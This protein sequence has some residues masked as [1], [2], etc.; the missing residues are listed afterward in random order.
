M[1]CAHVLQKQDT[2]TPG[3]ASASA[4]SVR[5]TLDS[6]SSAAV[7]V[8]FLFFWTSRGGFTCCTG[9]HQTTAPP[10]GHTTTRR[11]PA[12]TLIGYQEETAETSLHLWEGG[13]CP[14]GGGGPL[15]TLGP[16]YIR[17]GQVTTG[18]V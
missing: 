8:C 13:P 6:G 11:A 18:S 16:R 4:P 12:A 14:R 17:A 5:F 15:R 1:Q 3:V 10:T 7:S 9:T 2:H